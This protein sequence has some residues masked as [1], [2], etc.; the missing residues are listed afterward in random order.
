MKSTIIRISTGFIFAIV[1]VA[2]SGMV[3]A[4]SSQPKYG[5][6][7]KIIVNGDVTSMGYIP[8]QISPWDYYQRTPAI[9][10][11]VRYDVKKQEVVPFLAKAI[12][13]DPKANTITFNLR[14]GVKFHDGTVLDAKAVEWNLEEIRKS[15]NLGASWLSASSIEVKDDYTVVVHFHTW[16]NTF[17]RN[18]AWDSGMVSPTAFKKNG[19]DWAR[20][21]AVGTGPFKQVSFQ[22][23]VK[24]V[25]ERFDGYWQKG[26]PYLDRIEIKVIKDPTVQIAAFLRG[27]GD[28][29]E[30]VNAKYVHSLEGK[31][32]V[33]LIKDKIL[34]NLWS[35]AANSANPDTPF[36]NLKVRQAMSY[37]IDSKAIAKFLLYGQA[38]AVN[39]LVVPEAWSYNPEVKGYPY[40]PEKAKALLKEA[41]YPN[42][43]STTLYFS[44][45]SMVAK[46]FTAVQGYLAAVGIKAQ[47]EMLNTGKYGEMYYA[48]GWSS[49]IFAPDMLAYPEIGIM[50]RYFFEASSPLGLPKSLVH[51]EDL[52][53][54]LKRFVSTPDFE[55]QK[56][57]AKKVQYLLTDKY[58]LYTPLII[59][60]GVTAK[61]AYVKSANPRIVGPRSVY[62]FAD[63]WIDK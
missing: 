61:Y 46:V 50:T 24:K 62:S 40:N 33:L 21:H 3:F 22:R 48:T 1:L 58:C 63:E 28:M 44:S 25:F 15:G 37:A 29:I 39:Q 12:L 49:G 59:M 14:K 5:G 9:E 42:G 4:A 17:L 41:G 56:K 6:T 23:D 34:G 43:F 32:N 10:T 60:P 55:T 20:Q 38:R 54:V 35:L 31:P 19:L 18:M 53:A 36:A 51:P 30:N 2:F 47:P 7:L 26:K 45:D 8:D 52:E 13:Q 57:L 16:D 27:E 11:L